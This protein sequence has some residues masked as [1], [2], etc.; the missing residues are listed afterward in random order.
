VL[1][2]I[3]VV[4]VAALGGVALSERRT[5]PAGTTIAGVDV[6]GMTRDEAAAAVLPAAQARVLVMGALAAGSPVEDVVAR[7]G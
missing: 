6:G 3:V 2:I 1:A 7:W 5:V 4:A